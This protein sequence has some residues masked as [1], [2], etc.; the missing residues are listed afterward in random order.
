MPT[1]FSQSNCENRVDSEDSL[2]TV[3]GRHEERRE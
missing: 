3:E 1:G 2:E